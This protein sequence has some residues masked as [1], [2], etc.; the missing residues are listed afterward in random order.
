MR[1]VRTPSG[2]WRD[3][4]LNRAMLR[5]LHSPERPPLPLKPI[6]VLHE[7]Y[8]LLIHLVH[9]SHILVQIHVSSDGSFDRA[10]Q[11]FALTLLN[12]T[13]FKLARVSARIGTR[14][15]RMLKLWLSSETQRSSFEGRR[16]GLEFWKLCS[17]GN[18]LKG[19]PHRFVSYDCSEYNDGVCGFILGCLLNKR[20]HVFGCRWTV[21]CW[22]SH[23]QKRLE[24]FLD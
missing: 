18:P 16:D 3:S 10:D 2:Y 14:V 23:T 5:R 6:L 22:S 7:S 1:R 8:Y 21:D 11:I 17:L 15:F 20:T 4:F 12:W 13:R 9:H 19:E 24:K